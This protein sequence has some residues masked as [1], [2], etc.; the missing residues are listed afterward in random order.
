MTKVLPKKKNQLSLKMPDLLGRTPEV[1]MK[2]D[3]R[4]KDSMLP[5]TD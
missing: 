4:T 3:N 1:D 2:G 5:N